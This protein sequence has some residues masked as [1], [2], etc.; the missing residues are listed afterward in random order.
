MHAVE[1][2]KDSSTTIG[3]DLTAVLP[4]IQ[5]I[6]GVWGAISSDLETIRTMIDKNI[7]QVPPIIMDLG[8]DA[9]IR[10]WAAVASEADSFRVN[11]YVTEQQRTSLDQWTVEAWRLD[12]LL[13]PNCVLAGV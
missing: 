13:T 11:A 10:K 2:A 8:V 12:T 6:E 3:Q 9:A 5:K 1:S 7:E 4:V